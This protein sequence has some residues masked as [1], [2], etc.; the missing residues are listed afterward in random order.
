[1]KIRLTGTRTETEAVA[2]RL[3][4]ADGYRVREISDFY[5]NRGRSDLGRLYLD[6][7]V[8]LPEGGAR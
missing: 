2:D 4:H 7:E 3:V 5:P 1:M 8:A 6:V